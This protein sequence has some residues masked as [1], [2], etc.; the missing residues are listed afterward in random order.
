MNRQTVLI[1]GCSSGFGKLSAKSFHD[2]GWNVVATMRSPES[3]T[4]LS[5]LDDVLVTQ[6]DVTDPKSITQALNDGIAKFGGIDVVVNNA[7]YGGH[8]LFEQAGET[9]IRAMFDTN[10][11]G[12]MNV[13]RAVLPLMR[14]TGGGTIVNVTSMAGLIGLPGNSIYSAS[15]YALEGLSEAMA[16]EYLP[17]NIRIRLVAPGAY[18]TTRF[19]ANTDDN[20]DAGDEEL[21]A[22]SQKLRAHFKVLAD[23]MA[24]QGGKDADA[25]EVADKICECV[26][27]DETPV[28]NPVGVDAEMLT[29]MMTSALSRQEFLDQVAAM[30]IPPD[31][32]SNHA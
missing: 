30:V 22:Y 23:L 13:M 29:G 31:A 1:T 4:E 18:P 17:F 7:G 28:H 21:T 15:K 16:L 14:T 19:V 6:L 2:K 24:Q 8:A 25:Q 9:S 32:L 10:V 20:L 26:M 3:E 5:T 12:P 27:S 11:F